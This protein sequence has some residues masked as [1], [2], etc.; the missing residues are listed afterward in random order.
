MRAKYAAAIR[1]GIESGQATNFGSP[2]DRYFK[3]SEGVRW[4]SWMS[5]HREN[6][7]AQNAFD[8]A[9][10]RR[11]EEIWKGATP[12]EREALKAQH[13]LNHEMYY[14]TRAERNLRE[15]K[16]SVLR[17]EQRY[18]KDYPE[19]HINFPE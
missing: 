18:Q 1:Y 8:R 9:R 7:L 17:I 11:T 6:E 19:F 16:E 14:E 10:K 5:S 13:K 15:L 12:E 2:D 3:L 4:Y